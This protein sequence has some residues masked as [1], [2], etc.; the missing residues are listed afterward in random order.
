MSYLGSVYSNFVEPTLERY[1]EF[2]TSYFSINAQLY[3]EG[4]AP[5]S[6]TADMNYCCDQISSAV[7]ML[8][9]IAIDQYSVTSLL[10]NTAFSPKIDAANLT[11]K[12]FIE[13]KVIGP[14]KIQYLT[15]FVTN[16]GLSINRALNGAL[17]DTELGQY[18]STTI[19]DNV[20]KQTVRTSLPYN[21]NI[22]QL[23][24]V[25]P[26]DIQVPLTS[27][28]ISEILLPFINEFPSKKMEV[29]AE[30]TKV[31]STIASCNQKIK[32]YR[33]TFNGIK[34]DNSFSEE[35]RQNMESLFYNGVRNYMDIV[36]FITICVLHRLHV[37]NYNVSCAIDAYDKLQNL[38]SYDFDN[39]MET[40]YD[41]SLITS[42]KEDLSTNLLDGRI[43]AYEELA[44]N[45]F[46]FHN[47]MAINGI[48][49]MGIDGTTEIR[50]DEF[51]YPKAPYE[52]TLSILNIIG[53]SLT[54]LDKST[55]DYM[56]IYEDIVDKAG[57]SG[58]MTEKFAGQL[59]TIEQMP[60]YESTVNNIQS[61][62]V[63]DVFFRMLNEVKCYPDNMRNICD[64]LRGV[65]EQLSSLRRR[66]QSDDSTGEFKN[67]EC[68]Q[69]LIA[70]GESIEEEFKNLVEKI[71][72]AFMNRLRKLGNLLE[73]LS[74]NRTDKM[75]IDTTS[76]ADLVD[77]AMESCIQ[78][79]YEETMDIMSAMS[80]MFYVDRML[81]D[82]G[83]HVV[84]EAPTD[85]TV[86]Q[87]GGTQ[88]QTQAKNPSTT[89]VNVT[90]NSDTN[91]TKKT[92]KSK[93]SSDLISKIAQN[94]EEWFNN[95]MNK[96]DSLLDRQAAK[97]KKWLAA[98]K[99]GLQSR[100]YSNVEANILPY[101]EGMPNGTIPG[102]ITKMV[103][104]I[105]ALTPAVIEGVK[106]KGD[107]YKKLF[108]FINGVDF[109]KEDLNLGEVLTNHYKVGKLPLQ[110]KTYANS[111]LGRQVGTMISYCEVY[112]DSYI[113]NI[114]KQISNVKSTLTKATNL[115]KES[116]DS[117]SDISGL[118]ITE[119]DD[120][121]D[122][123]I[124]AN[125]STADQTQ[126]VKKQD[127]NAVGID[128][129]ARWMREAS[130]IYCGAVL[131]ALRDR[132]NDYFTVLYNLAPK[133]EQ[134]PT[135]N[136]ETQDNNQD[137]NQQ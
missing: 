3:L 99:A 32:S 127:P 4:T 26:I 118:Y 77:V 88:P 122:T 104:N 18:V 31:I 113:T 85:A 21:Y 19:G 48:N 33:D 126:Q 27:Q 105:N 45:I 6:I 61:G 76:Q 111:D 51:E 92:I 20:K 114:K 109:N 39:M 68:I 47:D 34:A 8:S 70:L 66:L 7:S 125:T 123:S 56:M 17:N 13:S 42:D 38:F 116:T 94:L 74:A 81:K 82:N 86:T 121:P 50:L 41:H 28:Y 80:E 84:I 10:K 55:D 108:T 35:D 97:N 1:R 102:E 65:Y 23:K 101:E 135:E 132:T 37:M 40:A 131:D 43:D 133:Q 83:L 5:E 72:I 106:T 119:A 36:S 136:T 120:A 129:K 24:N 12:G 52:D 53:E 107:V 137:N 54:I 25:M 130:K 49:P 96:F 75:E 64:T 134:T 78:E 59:A 103:A 57:L 71:A 100:R 15:Q 98:N 89:K 87:N 44:K 73:T 117:F 91:T 93:L 90:D 124:T 14:I 30:A 2:D 46:N 9:T 29:I 110:V 112:Y 79:Y 95:M 63:T 69:E 16:L 60:E 22:M 11:V 115:Y 58:D 67:S 128:V 62:M